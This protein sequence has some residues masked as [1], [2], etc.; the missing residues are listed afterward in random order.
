MEFEDIIFE[1]SEAH[2]H[3]RAMAVGNPKGI[4][5]LL[6]DELESRPIC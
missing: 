2:C 4:W 3:E 1:C 6:S 5:D